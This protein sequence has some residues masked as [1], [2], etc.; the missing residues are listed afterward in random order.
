MILTDGVVFL[1]TSVRSL[2]YSVCLELLVPLNR[3]GLK[4]FRIYADSIETR[5]QSK[6]RQ[7]GLSFRQ[8]STVDIS[9][10]LPPPGSS[11]R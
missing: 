1:G 11:T 9:D 10:R 2:S 7:K 8:G 3:I 4:I 5:Q 6:W